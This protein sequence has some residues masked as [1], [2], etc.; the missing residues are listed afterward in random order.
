MERRHA[1]TPR[2]QNLAASSRALHS[3]CFFFACRYRY[4]LNSWHRLFLAKILTRALSRT[5]ASAVHSRLSGKIATPHHFRC[6]RK[7]MFLDGSFLC[8]VPRA[9]IKSWAFSIARSRINFIFAL[10]RRRRRRRL[11]QFCRAGASRQATAAAE[12]I[13]LRMPAV[14]PS[15]HYRAEGCAWR[16]AG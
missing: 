2:T 16:C 14:A 7:D 4:I 3:C 10:L 6:R 12:K 5:V 13:R 15:P 11:R 9:C 1:F 8:N